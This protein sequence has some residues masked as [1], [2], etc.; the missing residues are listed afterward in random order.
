MTVDDLADDDQGCGRTSYL[1]HLVLITRSVP[2]FLIDSS[3]LL[4]TLVPSLD[5]TMAKGPARGLPSPLQAASNYLRQANDRTT[6]L[7]GKQ[8]KRTRSITYDTLT[9]NYSRPGSIRCRQL[10]TALL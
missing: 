4:P 1:Q 7:S 8:E 10:L 6:E 3:S 5:D 9:K 2:G